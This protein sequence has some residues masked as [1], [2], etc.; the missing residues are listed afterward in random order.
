MI[1]DDDDDDDECDA[2]RE[3]SAAAIGQGKNANKFYIKL[4]DEKTT[5]ECCRCVSVCMYVRSRRMFDVRVDETTKGEL[6]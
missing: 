3:Q 5:S 1:D 4:K 6:P 2:L